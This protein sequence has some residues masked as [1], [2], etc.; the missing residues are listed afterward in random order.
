MDHDVV[1]LGSGIGGA[2]L[3]AILARQGLDVAIV[4]RTPHP[5]FAIGESTIPYTTQALAALSTLY[6]VP[7]LFPKA[8]RQV[9]GRRCG[10]KRHFGYSYHRQ[11]EAARADEVHMV[12]LG[13]PEF[14]FF[15]QD[16][17]AH[18]FHVALGQGVTPFVGVGV[19]RVDTSADGAVVHLEDGRAL[20]ASYVVD[21]TGRGSVLARQ[22]GLRLQDPGLRTHTR[23]LFTHMIG[24]RPYDEIVPQAE[25]GMPGRLHEGTLHHVFDGGWMWIIPFDNH[26]DSDNPLCSV[27]LQLDARRFPL[28]PDLSPEDEFASW[29][30]RFPSVAAHLEG[31]VPVRPWVRTPRLQ[32]AS[33]RATGER[34]AL[35]P[36]A[37][38]FVDPLYSR[39]LSCTLDGVKA[40]ADCILTAHREQ[41]WRHD[42]FADLDGMYHR[43]LEAHDDLAYGSLVSWRDIELWKV[44]WYVWVQSTATEFFIMLGRHEF[45][46]EGD[47]TL[48]RTI[49]HHP[50]G[51]IP[52]YGAYMRGAVAIMERVDCGETGAKEAAAELL[53][54]TRAQ[55]FH[56][57][58]A[59]DFL[60]TRRYSRP[61]HPL[62]DLPALAR[63]GYWV[64]TQA[65]ADIKDMIMPLVR[66][67]VFRYAYGTV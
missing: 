67:Y 31:A 25:H 47:D 59:Q 6:D 48:L 14:H 55:P 38:G 8:I 44:W 39:G 42:R 30:A 16:L 18:L 34:W 28:D 23:T 33:S 13:E 43:L 24:V 4:D 12:W 63:F 66:K 37:Y 7:E 1:I 40:L 21:G 10:V 19:D 51:H 15:R 45:E 57:G 64:G 17:D 49:D 52:D 53:A 36:H 2:S 41:D 61:P 54:W 11:G 32:F 56:Y 9:I 27:G 26:E 46:R 60:L 65:R 22:H 58:P 3:A 20:S 5:R 35:L 62:W 29:V 50:D